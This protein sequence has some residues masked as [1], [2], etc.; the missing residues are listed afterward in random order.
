MEATAD[1]QLDRLDAANLSDAD[2]ATLASIT[3]AAAAVDSPHLSPVPPRQVLLRL[4]HGWDGF[5]TDH[6]FVVRSTGGAV[7]GFVEVGYPHW[8][9][10]HLAGLDL[11]VHPDARGDDAV[12]D[13]LLGKAIDAC[14]TDSRLSLVSDA[15][16][17]SWLAG[18]WERHGWPVASHAAQRRIVVSEVDRPRL[19]Q[20]LADAEGSSP[21][22]DVEVLPS[23]TPDGWVQDMIEVRR[24]MNDAPLDD[25]NIDD[26]EWSAERL[27]A[28]DAALASRELRVH[29][30][31]ARRRSDGVLGGF[32]AVVVEEA[33]PTVGFQEDT[34][35][36]GT[37]RGHRL[38]LRLKAAML[39]RL[40][41]LEPQLQTI[42]TWNAESNTHMLAVNDAIGCV[43]VGRAIEVQT[44]L[45]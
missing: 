37:H 41:A 17:D 8:D 29:R 24:A 9:N 21:T 40:A 30:L 42:D 5:P 35:V 28:S 7:A 25:L 13:A 3:N 4:R 31:V 45:A 39:Q 2:A 27:V 20:L 6:V 26:E 34:A 18:Y 10:L 43:V 33:R 1:V 22:Y 12:A 19:D 11:V 15:W 38:G 14:R 23:P 44:T 32:T 16:R 36:V